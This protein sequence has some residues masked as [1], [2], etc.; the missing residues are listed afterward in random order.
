M[1]DIEQFRLEWV[2]V[3]DTKVCPDC[4]DRNTW[5][6]VT[7]EEWEG[8]GL[9]GLGFTVCGGHCRCILMPVE[10]MNI[11][12]TL[13]GT[14]VILRDGQDNLKIS[15][16]IDTALYTELDNLVLEFE[17]ITD[18]WNLPTKYYEIG[19]PQARV[20]FMKGLNKQVK[21]NKISPSIMDS[22][23]KTNRELR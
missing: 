14:G 16:E 21:T 17:G 1:A 10:L 3:G 4:V 19:D 12:A 11:F 23:K 9:P 15:R 22:L 6:A 7:L 20:D 5:P 8:L 2:T 13:R 18:N